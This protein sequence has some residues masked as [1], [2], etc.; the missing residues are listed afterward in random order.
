MYSIF[1][2]VYH[3]FPRLHGRHVSTENILAKILHTGP[4]SLYAE[5]EYKAHTA[6]L[7]TISEKNDAEKR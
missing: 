5:L 1:N 4:A 7:R 6:W 2:H 3:H